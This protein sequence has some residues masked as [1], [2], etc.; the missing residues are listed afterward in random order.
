MKKLS[1][2]FPIAACLILILSNNLFG[3]VVTV[4][5]ATAFKTAITNLQPGD[6]IDVLNGTYDLNAYVAI[7]V[8]G[9]AAQPILIRAKNRGNVTFINK[10]FFDLKVV[11]YITI[12]GF[13]F[14]S[15]DGTVI[16]I[17]SCHYVRVT[18]NIFHVQET[19]GQKWVI[20]Q[21]IYNA[22][23]PNSDHNRIDHN[24]FENK[25]LVGNMITL[26]GFQGTPTRSSQYDMIDHNHFRN[27]G[28][29][30]A[31]GMET[32]RL[33]VSSLSGTSGF[34]TV[35]YNLFEDCN[36][37]PEFVSV[38][39][40]DD[41]IRYNTFRSCKGTL[42]FRQTSRSIAEGNFFLGNG[43][44]STGGVRVYKMDNTIFN[45]YFA[46][47]RGST[48]DAALTITNGDADSNS[49]NQSAHWRPIRTSFVFNT[50]VNNKSNI[51]MGFTNGGSY[52]KPPRQTTIANNIIV[53]S[54]GKL[55]N[56]YTTP[57]NQ[58]LQSNIMYPKDSAVLGITASANEIKVVDP[59]LAFGDSLWRL[60]SVSPAIDS[61][62]GV[63]DYVLLDIDGQNRG[64]YKDIG[65]DEYS[66]GGILKRPLAPG[67]VGPNS[68]ESEVSP[69]SL[70][71]TLRV[72]GFTNAGTGLMIPDSVICLIRNAASPYALVDSAKVYINLSGQGTASFQQ[73]LIG[74]NYYIVIKHR[75]AIE[76]WSQIAAFPSYTPFYDFTSAQ[77]RA[78]AGNL[79][80]VGSKWCIYN[81]DV[82]QDGIIDSGDLGVVDNDNA[83][84]L[85]GY[86]DSD[87]NGDNIVD[88]G[89]MGI[90]DNNNAGYI[91]KIIPAKAPY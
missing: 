56:Y 35:E 51:E 61:A 32:I 71:L 13:V 25:S 70:T 57:L 40:D 43:V 21:D 65:T 86:I 67:D 9:T 2:F 31:N 23:V 37:D 11:S 12:E 90:V 64:A 27:T 80:Q 36:G 60:S 81:G 44:D 20:I 73:A 75:N 49:T 77:N 30:I 3:R 59:L 53:G 41:I 29:R 52:T 4:S 88:S 69:V 79:V 45:N 38:K 39:T 82:N 63:Y 5:T 18:R 46:N 10:S 78:Y 28:P 33:G 74:I 8:S 66:A 91:G 76:T 54:T 17:E 42:C 68:P 55:V 83:N 72:Q 1:Y 19:V 14:N 84:Y 26:D 6:T 58:T 87:V 24:L 47:L 16:K 22:T 62:A 34:T 89:D 15:T 50:L 85:N 7:T 48:W